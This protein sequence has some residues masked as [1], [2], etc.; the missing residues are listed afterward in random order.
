MST[1]SATPWDVTGAETA[2]RVVALHGPDRRPLWPPGG[3]GPF[4]GIVS[5]GL[6]EELGADA[7]PDW[8]RWAPWLDAALTGMPAAL[9]IVPAA[10]VGAAR[11]CGWTTFQ[12]GVEAAV[13][14]TAA[15]IK[16]L[17]RQLSAGFD[18]DRVASV[19]LWQL[20]EGHTSSVWQLTITP[21]NDG[22]PARA[23][24]NVARDDAASE[25]LLQTAE[26]IERLTQSSDVPVARVLHRGTAMHGAAA[27]VAQEWVEGARELA[28]LRRRDGL[29]RL[30][31]IE[32]FVTDADAP[33]RILGAIGRQLDDDDHA[34]ASYAATRLL[35]DGAV[36]GPIEGTVA[37]PRFDVDHGDWVWGADGPALVA[38]ARGSEVVPRASAREYMLDL[39]PERHGI[40]DGD[41]RRA[42]QRGVTAAFRAASSAWG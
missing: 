7:A 29:V 35:L 34:A 2:P 36:P 14:F 16:P 28:F 20:K 41:G 17:L 25:E 26:E 11:R 27:V 32:R 19:E 5:R 18:P 40:S 1:T 12:E 10:I 9:A 39:W 4:H 33:A 15:S 38:L 42:I 31:A 30:H 3:A 37:L 24:L 23:A 22:R 6:M 21:K 8:P 13:A